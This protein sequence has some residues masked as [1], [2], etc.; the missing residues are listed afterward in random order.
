MLEVNIFFICRFYFFIIFT[1]ILM[2]LMKEGWFSEMIDIWPGIALSLEVKKILHEE[3][4]R[5][6]NIL[7]VET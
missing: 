3:K 7:I 2:N 5:Y 4:S 1:V 6:Q